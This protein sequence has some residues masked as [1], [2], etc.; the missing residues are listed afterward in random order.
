MRGLRE[1]KQTKITELVKEEMRQKFTDIRK[2][3]YLGMEGYEKYI[4]FLQ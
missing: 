1:G 2:I 4:Y 3:E